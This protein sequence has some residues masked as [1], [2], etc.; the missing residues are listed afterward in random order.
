MDILLHMFASDNVQTHIMKILLIID[1]INAQMNV[2]NALIL[3]IVSIVSQII[4]Y[5]QEDAY[6]AVLLS[7]L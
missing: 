7:L 1:A 6:R 4:I 2:P 3:K 5:I